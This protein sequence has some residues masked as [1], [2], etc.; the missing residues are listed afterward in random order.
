[1]SPQLSLPGSWVT[2][3]CCMIAK[4]KQVPQI[5]DQTGLGVTRN[6][7]IP[8]DKRWEYLPV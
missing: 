2:T 1:M 8:A 5:K 6:L 3:S 4:G 7:G